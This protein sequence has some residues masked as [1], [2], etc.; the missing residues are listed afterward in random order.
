MIV[1]LPLQ[2]PLE[3]VSA[4]PCC[5]VPLIVGGVVFAGPLIRLTP[6]SPTVVPTTTTAS[7]A[8][9]IV[10][11]RAFRIFPSLAVPLGVPEPSL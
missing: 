11:I 3:A 10:S 5:A 2:E 4:C 6:A 7:A 1:P 8:S 9:A